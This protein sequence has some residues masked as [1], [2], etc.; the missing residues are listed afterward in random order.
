MRRRLSVSYVLPL[1]WNCDDG[2][3]QELTAYLRRLGR[4]CEVIVV[5][6]SS[7]VLFA[8]HRRASADFVV[9]V[10]PDPRHRYLNGKVNGVHTGVGLATHDAIVIADD[11]VRYGDDQLAR[12]AMAL[13]NADLVVPQNVFSAWPW[14]ARWD[15]ARSLV[16]RAF[17]D[18][19]P[20]TV[21][22]QRTAFVACDGYDGDVLFEN[23]ELIR[24]ISATGAA[25]WSLP[26]LFIARLPPTARCFWSQRIRQA[27]DSQ[28]QPFRRA[29]ELAV[30]PVLAGAGWRVCAAVWL[31]VTGAAEIGR[32]R[33]GG[34]SVFPATTA[35]WAPVWLVE[36]GVCSWLAAVLRVRGGVRYAGSR[37]VLAAH[38]PRELR[39]RMAARGARQ[40]EHGTSPAHAVRRRTV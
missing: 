5:D 18:D 40:R 21:G 11:D 39:L 2:R 14:H 3:L 22:L 26:D 30:L 1:R 10:R 12:M 17:G 16:N 25:V 36:R 34:R 19:Y 33:S 20:G 15:A 32:R 31:G 4:R 24:T 6:G 27:Y 35:T 8:G 38:Q 7:P 13:E 9:H 37:I 28:A 29:L 23:L